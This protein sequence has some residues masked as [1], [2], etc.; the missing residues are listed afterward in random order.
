M[1]KE[2]VTFKQYI[3]GKWESS[4]NTDVINVFN[5]ATDELVGRVASGN[6]EDAEKALKSAEKAQKS[7]QKLPAIQRAQFLKAFTKEI[8]ANREIL[9]K[10]LTEEQGKLYKVALF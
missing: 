3:H 2:I 6:E 5:P 9:A 4:S 7:W 8:Q 1:V 10:V